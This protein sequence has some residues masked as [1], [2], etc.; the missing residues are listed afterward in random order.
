MSNGYSD[1]RVSLAKL[2][3]LRN[4]AIA[5]I[6]VAAPARRDWAGSGSFA[7]G[8]AGTHARER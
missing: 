7:P 4:A 2:I 3:A 1:F 8:V 5:T 6:T